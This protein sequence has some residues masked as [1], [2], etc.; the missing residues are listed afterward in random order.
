[1]QGIIQGTQ[2]DVIPLSSLLS[3]VELA[4]QK[5]VWTMANFLS[6]LPK[7]FIFA[8]IL[9]LIEGP[10]KPDPGQS[11]AAKVMWRTGLS[12]IDADTKNSI[13]VHVKQTLRDLVSDCSVRLR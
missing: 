9:P 3:L 11:E 1:M 8:F 13:L 6:L 2:L 4:F 10:G 12:Q 5:Q 7:V